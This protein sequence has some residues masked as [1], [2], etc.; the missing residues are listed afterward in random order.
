MLA[1]Q[2]YMY[3]RVSGWWISTPVDLVLPTPT[4][5]GAGAVPIQVQPDA[6]AGGEDPW[7][8]LV[9]PAALPGQV[10]PWQQGEQPAM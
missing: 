1:L 8:A 6:G 9:W 5:L 4:N 3:M 7:Q 10:S 2:G